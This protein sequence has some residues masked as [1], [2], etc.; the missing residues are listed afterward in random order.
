MM[1]PVKAT[2]PDFDETT[3]VAAAFSAL[4]RHCSGHMHANEYGVLHGRNHEYLHQFRVALRRLRSVLRVHRSLLAPAAYAGIAAEI[5][6][7]SAS[8]G[9]A[10]DWDVFLAET[11]TPL[12]RNARDETALTSFRRRCLRQRLHAGQKLTEALTSSRYLALNK[13]CED[14]AA[15]PDWANDPDVAQKLALPLRDFAAQRIAGR[16]NNAYR[17]ATVIESAQSSDSA[18]LHKL[19]IA[20]K[21]LRYTV[22]FFG[23]LFEGDAARDYAKALAGL[24][25]ALGTLNDCATARR[26]IGVVPAGRNAQAHVRA[27]GLA[28]EWIAL[29]EIRSHVAFCIA[30]ARWRALPPFW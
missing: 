25:D 30:T 4:V 10:R 16:A 21:K 3:S 6:W 13:A 26:L 9:A 28:G 22:E 18:M 7:L 20:A 2:R 14:L 5:A 27:C 19:R 23:D 29:V 15:A 24:Q 12:Q 11:L 1:R 8:L 17:L